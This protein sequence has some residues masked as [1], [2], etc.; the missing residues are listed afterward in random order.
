MDIPVKMKN[1]INCTSEI[2]ENRSKTVIDRESPLLQ[3]RYGV[4]GLVM[5]FILAESRQDEYKQNMAGSGGTE[6]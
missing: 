5:A 1:D 4:R 2:T 6:I 3:T